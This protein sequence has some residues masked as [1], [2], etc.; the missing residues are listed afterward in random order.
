M[1]K[2]PLLR[3][4]WLPTITFPV[5]DLALF[6]LV[7]RLLKVKPGMSC[8]ELPLKS[9]VEVPASWPD[10]RGLNLPEIPMLP[11]NVFVPVPEVVM[12]P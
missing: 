8:A 10:A 11:T 6:P 2:V 9:T 1:P 7:V 3:F 5:S 4:N 12:F